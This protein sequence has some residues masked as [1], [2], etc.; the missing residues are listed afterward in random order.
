MRSFNP[1]MFTPR[2]LAGFALIAALAGPLAAAPTAQGDRDDN[3]NKARFD[4][5]VEV[6]E[7]LLDVLVTDRKG[8]VVVGLEPSDFVVVE[9]GKEHPVTGASFYSNRFELQEGQ[10]GRIKKPQPGEVLADRY[11]ILF[12]QDMRRIA[13]DDRSGRIVRSQFEAGRQA[14]RWVREEMLGGDWV[15]VVGYDVSLK[16]Y[17]DFTRDRK[18]LEQAIEDA[19][20][21]RDVDNQWA[22]RRPDLPAEQPSLQRY[23]PAG[24]ELSKKSGN[25]YEA[26][27][28]VAESTH[29]IIGRKNLMLFTIGF[30]EIRQGVTRGDER[31]YPEL[32]ES[33]NDNNV[34]V[35]PIDLVPSS[36]EHTQENFLHQLA[37][38]SGGLYQRTFVSYITPMRQVADEANGYY[39]LSYQATHPANDRGYREVK[40]KARNPEWKLRARQGYRYGT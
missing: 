6:S 30:G 26:L 13:S 15:A 23:L 8:N 39:L 12:F 31:Y 2:S 36:F 9:D 1:A 11:F 21:G 33:L 5:M 32:K 16:V 17:S 3:N 40:V 18:S 34:A 19:R 22:S 29:D 27:S 37:D 38:E 24:K 10:E 35:Y 7:V 4:E 20:L 25:M 14:Q 28:L